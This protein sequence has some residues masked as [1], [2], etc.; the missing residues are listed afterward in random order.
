MIDIDS[1]KAVAQKAAIDAGHAVVR[2]WNSY[3]QDVRDK[4]KTDVVSAADLEAD[5]VISAAIRTAFPDHRIL[6]EEGAQTHSFDYSG[7]LWIIDPIDGT[8]NYVRGHPYFGIS[9]AFALDGV[10]VAGCVHAPALA[11]TFVATKHGGATLNGTIISPS[12]PNGL[13]R[14]VVSTG[15]PHD[16]SDIEKPLR[17]VRALLE[18]CQDIRRSASPVLDIA[19]VAMGRLDAH[20]ETLFAWD[21]AAAGLI[22]TEA[23]AQR[24]NLEA[25]P[26]NVPVD[27]FGGEVVFSAP[28]IF[29]ELMA[30]LA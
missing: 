10:V 16:K 4:G 29:Q 1:V 2:H 26:I 8:A 24:G 25:V 12:S 5:R 28:S 21:V 3:Q 23:G 6:S 18:S 19:Y 14:S 30:Q 13:I 7:P 17:R 11:E 20:T 15:F 9:V 22:A 27:L